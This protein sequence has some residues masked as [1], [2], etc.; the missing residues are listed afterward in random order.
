MLAPFSCHAT[1]GP[2]KPPYEPSALRHAAGLVLPRRGLNALA[3]RGC[4]L[5]IRQPNVLEGRRTLARSASALA[6]IS[7]ARSCSS[8]G[9]SR[10]LYRQPALQ[11]PTKEAE[12]MSV[13]ALGE[14]GPVYTACSTLPVS[15]FHSPAAPSSTITPESVVHRPSSGGAAISS[16]RTRGS[17]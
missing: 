17:W 13:L 15:S 14:C 2:Q 5:Y 3:P 16:P 8:S 6:G 11:W 4:T 12:F 10:R 7:A 1:K 9:S